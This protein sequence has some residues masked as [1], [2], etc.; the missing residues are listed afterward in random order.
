MSRYIAGNKFGNLTLLSEAPSRTRKVG[1][2]WKRLRTWTVQCDCGNV[3]VS[4]ETNLGRTKS[5]AKCQYGSLTRFEPGYRI[6]CLTVVR[7]FK[8]GESKSRSN[9]HYLMDCDCGKQ[10]RISIGHLKAIPH[11]TCGCHYQRHG[12]S[13]KR[14]ENSMRR[15]AYNSWT[16]LKD[17]CYSP[18]NRQFPHYGGRGIILSE[19]WLNFENF[20]RDMGDRPDGGSLDRIDPDGP[21]SKENCRWANCRT[22]AINRGFNKIYNFMGVTLPLCQWIAKIQKEGVLVS[23]PTYPRRQSGNPIQPASPHPPS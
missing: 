7:Y 4:L 9:A 17:R 19:S 18:K 3:Y 5:C 12:F 23:L 2:R 20:Y 13:S 6:G 8:T 21:Y 11:E 15:K 10:R 16:H 1:S 22:Q 14:P